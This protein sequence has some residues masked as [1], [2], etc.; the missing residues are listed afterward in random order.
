MDQQ[1]KL[2][3][4]AHLK[5]GL[6]ATE[7]SNLEELDIT[8]ARTLKLKKQLHEA[9]RTDSILGLFELNEAALEILLDSVK[10]NLTPAIEAFGIGELVDEEVKELSKS[11][12][13][14]KLLDREMQFAATAIAKKIAQTAVI[15]NNAETVLALAKALSELQ[16][17]FFGNGA[18]SSPIALPG[19]GSFER[20]LR[21]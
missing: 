10:A 20:H 21:N 11:I 1:T 18:H 5:N 2:L 3:A 6:T 7:V 13:G 16:I 8:Y 12:N 9:E 14:G 19:A 15:S 4:L 17:A